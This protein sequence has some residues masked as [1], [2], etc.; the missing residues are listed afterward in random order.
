MI[1]ASCL[2]SKISRNAWVRGRLRRERVTHGEKRSKS[3]ILP[4]LQLISVNFPRRRTEKT[5]LWLAGSNQIAT[6]T[7]NQ[8][9]RLSS[10][11]VCQNNW[12]CAGVFLSL[13]LFLYFSPVVI[14]LGII[15]WL[16]LTLCQYHHPR[17][18]QSSTKMCLLCRLQLS[19]AGYYQH[20]RETGSKIADTAYLGGTGY[21]I[22]RIAW[23]LVIKWDFVLFLE[24][25]NINKGN[26]KKRVK[27]RTWKHFK[28][29][30]N[31][32]GLAVV[33]ITPPS[34]IRGHSLE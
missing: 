7:T 29:L 22:F 16:T 13:L 23:N 6:N 21:F 19:L 12:L 33:A 8:I 4:L 17:W 14:S 15:F 10:L 11:R 25:K 31:R 30:G 34:P 27:P 18:R 9:P 2:Q 3:A 1:L 32:G 20:L 26:K 28:P 24:M 5:W